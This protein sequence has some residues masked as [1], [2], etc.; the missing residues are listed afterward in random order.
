[1]KRVISFIFALLLLAACGTGRQASTPDPK[2]ESSPS[3][4]SESVPA[5][6]PSSSEPSSAESE[7]G[8][9][10]QENIPEVQKSEALP[11]GS[12]VPESTP[13]IQKNETLLD[14]HNT[15]LLPLDYT[16]TGYDW[17]WPGEPPSNWLSLFERFYFC[18]T[19]QRPSDVYGADWPVEEMTA[20]I[21][22]YFDD[23]TQQMVITGSSR[24]T[25]NAADNTLH[26]EG[27]RGGGAPDPLRAIGVER[28]SG[29]ITVYYE[30]YDRETETSI[31]TPYALTA[32]IMEDGSFRYRS[33]HAVTSESVRN[34]EN[35]AGVN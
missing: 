14:L 15:Y 10:A 31:G 8:D 25:Y 18:E 11:E 3:S 4:V 13:G 26:Y 5:P 2:P 32:E 7:P 28:D 30:A 27:G 19:G 16:A 12:S 1:M 35:E 17:D 23:V 22:R 20:T 6:T 34:L 33:N 9:S 29:R 21:N 24:A